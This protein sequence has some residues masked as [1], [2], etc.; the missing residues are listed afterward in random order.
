M[1]R[2]QSIA[3]ALMGV[4]LLL[5]AVTVMIVPSASPAAAANTESVQI[6]MPFTGKWA[7][8][9]HVDP[10]YVDSCPGGGYGC[11]GF[12]SHPSVHQSWSPESG[13]W[14]TD[15][16]YAGG[17][18]AVKLRVSNASGT[19]TYSWKSVSGSCGGS[20]GINVFVDG[21]H[22]GWLYY[23]HLSN[24]VTSGPI[25]NGMTLGT[26]ALQSGGCNPGTHM[27]AEFRNT[28]SGYSC[29]YD[30][31]NPGVT[32]GGGTA[33]ALLG[34]NNTGQKQECSGAQP[35]TEQ[36]PEEP[37]QPR[38]QPFAGDFNGDGFDDIGLRRVSSGTFYIRQGPDFDVQISFTWA[39]GYHLEPFTGDFTGDQV[40]DIG[41]RRIATGELYFRD[42]PDFDSQVNHTWAGTTNY[43]PMGGDINGDGTDD[44][45]LRKIST[46]VFYNRY[47]P[48]PLFDTA[49]QN[50]YMWTGG[51][52]L[53]PFVGDF[54]GNGYDD[55]GLRRISTG[56]LY[57]RF[58]PTYTVQVEH[59][60]AANNNYQPPIVGDF[61]GDG[62]DDVALRRISTGMWYFRFGPAPAFDTLPQSTHQW[63]Y[64]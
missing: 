10:P 20:T 63:A 31:G 11:P 23:T 12:S 43:Q 28:N 51:D 52:H 3:R 41:L 35:G 48:A 38:Y 33:I 49:P 56:E 46:G 25:T 59:T 18:T 21:V 24:A 16:Y 19:V 44:M 57:F 6:G 58:A 7:Y 5:A 32:L 27:H 1:F 34:A 40:D 4:M 37:T 45:V 14:G 17:S 47:G 42:G 29:Y 61:N 9:A 2:T 13:E 53:Q 36:P 30:Q 55:Y 62:V 22:V 8:N 60:W 39:G 50:T 64:G 54:D 26:M 15:L